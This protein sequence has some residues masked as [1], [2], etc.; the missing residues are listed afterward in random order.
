VILGSEQPLPSAGDAMLSSGPTQAWVVVM[1]VADETVTISQW[2][3]LRLGKSAAV[4]CD[5]AQDSVAIAASAAK[6]LAVRMGSLS[7]CRR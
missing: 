7:K 3:G 2:P 1:P 4:A 6:K 5:V